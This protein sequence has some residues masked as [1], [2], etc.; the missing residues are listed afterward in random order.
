MPV[1]YLSEPQRF[2]LLFSIEENLARLRRK[3]PRYSLLV[4]AGRIQHDQRQHLMEIV[5]DIAAWDNRREAM[6]SLTVNRIFESSASS[7]SNN[8]PV[9]VAGYLELERMLKDVRLEIKRT[10]RPHSAA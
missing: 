6:A 5:E 8:A 2:L 1:S 9:Q 3:L 10:I 4:T 7:G